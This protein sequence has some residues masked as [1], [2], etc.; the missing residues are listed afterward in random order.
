MRLKL[1]ER[2]VAGLDFSQSQ[3]SQK[4][5]G[6]STPTAKRTPKIQQLALGFMV[7][8]DHVTVDTTSEPTNAQNVTRSRFCP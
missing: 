2:D 7:L 5:H 3:S 1:H 8:L 6:R 4:K